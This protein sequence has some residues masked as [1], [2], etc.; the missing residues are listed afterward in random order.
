MPLPN[1][2]DERRL[3][4]FL[5]SGSIVV[6]QCSPH[7]PEEFDMRRIIAFALSN[8]AVGFA[9]PATAQSYGYDYGNP[10]GYVSEHQREHDQLRQESHQVHHELDDQ[11]NAAHEQGLDP[12]QHAQLHRDL[13]SEHRYLDHARSHEHRRQHQ[14][15]REQQY[16]G[17]GY[18]PSGY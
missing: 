16:Y 3:S 10:Y 18:Q 15:N 12:W 2:E 1:R 9:A 4:I 6:W 14:W 7:K 5:T 13:R 8:A 11:H 17:Y